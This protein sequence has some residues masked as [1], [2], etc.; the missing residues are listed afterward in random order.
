MSKVVQFTLSFTGNESDKHLI[1]FYDV[2]QAL[3]GFQRSIALTTHLVLNNE[4]ITQAPA[5]KGA[6]I[7][8]LPSEPGSWKI[9]GIVALLG[10]ATYNLGTAPANTPLGHIVH[11]VYD[12]V[13]S[14]NLGVHVDYEK[15][16]GQLYEEAKAKEM[17]LKE[18]T[19]SQADSLTEKCSSSIL[20]MHRPIA[21][22]QTAK[23]GTIITT[24]NNQPM[25]LRQNLTLETFTFLNETKKCDKQEEIEG[26]V[27]SYSKNTYKGRIFVKDI[28]WA[29]PFELAGKG[30]TTKKEIDLI[31]RSLRAN[32]LNLDN[33]D[34]NICCTAFRNTSRSGQIKSFLITKV[35]KS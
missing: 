12:Y 17:G 35:S 19:Q 30:R 34:R 27:S 11:S 18:I 24:V 29:V 28:G 20:N 26:F 31:T 4:I 7:Y 1:D 33:A 14:E 2:S 13:V 23:K 22:T 10:T 15:T 8:A 5:L 32:A 21:K 3:I 9:T 25:R 6:T 16:L